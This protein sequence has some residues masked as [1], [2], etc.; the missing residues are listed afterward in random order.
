[1]GVET[2]N[3][4]LGSAKAARKI[5]RDLGKRPSNWLHQAAAK[6]VDRTVKDWHEW[7]HHARLVK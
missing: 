4:H 2:A 3:V 5:L 6:M 7:R 1:M